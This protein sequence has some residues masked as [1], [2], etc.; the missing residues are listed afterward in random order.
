MQ[1]SSGASEHKTHRILFVTDTHGCLKELNKLLERMELDLERDSLI[2]LGDLMD[3]GPYSYETYQRFRA[4]KEKMGERCIILMG[5]HDDMMLHAFDTDVI[6]DRWMRNR[7]DL[8][9]KSF[10]ENGSDISTAYPWFS[11]LPL[12][13]ET[14]RFICAHAGLVADRPEDNSP[15]DLFWDREMA[16]GRPYAGK[17]VFYGH[18]TSRDAFMR[19]E[20]GNE[21][22]LQ[23]GKVYHLP[24]RGQI[25]LDTG[26]VY[27]GKLTGLI[28]V[29]GQFQ[30]YC[31]PCLQAGGYCE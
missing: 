12:Y 3:R 14:D 27:G 4:L 15:Y 19:D 11:Q 9:L 22:S 24:Y 21:K 30:I 7:G 18:T 17:M 10:E 6:Y 13:Y 5:N 23:E 29:G 28:L 1:S 8:T 31:V 20:N 25:C 2:C 16:Y 26:C